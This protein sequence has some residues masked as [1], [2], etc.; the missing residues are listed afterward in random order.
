[1]NT[2]ADTDDHISQDATLKRGDDITLTCSAEKE[3]VIEKYVTE[4]YLI[5][6]Y[7]DAFS[8]IFT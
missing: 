8:G 1:M 5:Q 3:K 7:L 4:L 2:P 6:I